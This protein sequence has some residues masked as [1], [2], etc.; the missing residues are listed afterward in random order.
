M[1]LKCQKTCQFIVDINSLDNKDDI[2]V[3]DNGKLFKPSSKVFYGI[4]N[5]SSDFVQVASGR[6]DF[7]IRMRYYTHCGTQTFR[8]TSAI[9]YGADETPLFALMAYF[10]KDDID[11]PI[12]YQHHGNNQR[13]EEYFRT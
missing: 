4:Y 3:D 12:V 8:K 9:L 2:A 1:P 7:F 11:V 6:N 10:L 5:S 13:Y